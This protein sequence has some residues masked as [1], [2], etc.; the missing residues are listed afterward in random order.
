MTSHD[1]T[2]YYT[3]WHNLASLYVKLHNITYMISANMYSW[4]TSMFF[5]IT[6]ESILN[7]HVQVCQKVCICQRNAMHVCARPSSCNKTSVFAQRLD[8]QLAFTYHW[9]R[10][11]NADAT[12]D[13][14]TYYLLILHVNT[15]QYMALRSV[16]LHYI[17]WSL[18]HHV[19]LLYVA[20]HYI[21]PHY[22][23]LHYITIHYIKLS[24]DT[25]H[26]IKVHC[27]TLHGITSHHNTL[28]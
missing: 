2:W 17:T 21:R 8:R 6:F 7:E 9:L 19:I 28:K 11:P 1:I 23:T 5:L 4:G 27:M 14:S 26:Y 10:R 18:I 16:T 15:W 20:L 13:C 22:I 25:L 24:Y 12:F 3:T